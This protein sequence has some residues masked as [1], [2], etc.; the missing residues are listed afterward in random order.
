MGNNLRIT[1][2]FPPTKPNNRG[3]PLLSR[4][5]TGK[6]R[7]FFT[8]AKRRGT[9]TQPLWNKKDESYSHLEEYEGSKDKNRSSPYRM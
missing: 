3:K 1:P 7:W 8:G 5:A 4:Q 9:A 2:G 6:I